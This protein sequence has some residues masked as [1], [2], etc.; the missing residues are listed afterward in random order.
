MLLTN[1]G[2]IDADT[3]QGMA[4]DLTDAGPNFN[5]GTIRASNGATLTIY[6]ATLDNTGGTVEA[7]PGSVVQLYNMSLIGGVLRD[8]D[9]NS[10][11]A[12]RNAGYCALSGV[13]IEGGFECP[14]Y[15]ATY[16]YDTIDLQGPMRLNSVGYTT[17]LIV[18]T[19]P[20]TL[21]GAGGTV[22][23]NTQAN[24]IYGANANNQ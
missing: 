19:S 5:D 22:A 10:A 2:L 9:G 18:A 21:A 6:P 8:V 20:F 3:S 14:N 7:A 1:H 13:T 16:L 15:T 11:G 24:R 23:A 17:D 12:V 4:L